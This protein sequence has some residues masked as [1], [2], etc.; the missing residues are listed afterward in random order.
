MRQMDTYGT[1]LTNLHSLVCFG[2]LAILTIRHL[3]SVL[4][5]TD[6]GRRNAHLEARREGQKRFSSGKFIVMRKGSGDTLIRTCAWRLEGRR[7]SHQDPGKYQVSRIGY[8]VSGFRI[9][10]FIQIRYGTVHE[11]MCSRTRALPLATCD[12]IVAAPCHKDT[13]RTASCICLI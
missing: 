5:A 4:K 11:T 13:R 2:K 6:R 8:Q 12:H 1:I 7:A 9:S 3:S 10:A